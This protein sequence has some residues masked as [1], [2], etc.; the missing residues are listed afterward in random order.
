MEV[1]VQGSPHLLHCNAFDIQLA[2]MVNRSLLIFTASMI[3]DRRVIEQVE[4]PHLSDKVIKI[5]LL[6]VVPSKGHVID[7]P[8]H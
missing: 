1:Q 7:Y 8:T 3:I 5:N 4:R 2:F 6:D